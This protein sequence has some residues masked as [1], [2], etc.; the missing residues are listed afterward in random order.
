[1]AI[2]LW[3]RATSS[4]VQKVRWALGELG[5]SYEHIPLAGR[6]GGNKTPEYLAMN[7]NGTVPT[8]RDG[9]LVLWESHAILRYLAAEYGAASLWPASPG[10]RAICDQ[11]TDWAVAEFQKGWIEV[12][13]LL[14]RTPEAQR[15]AERIE[16]TI[17]LTERL[18]G[19]LDGGLASRPWLGGERFTYA[20]I[21]V[22]V[23]MYRWTTMPIARQSHPN[24]ERW[25][26][27]LRERP[28]YR[29][30]VE[31]DYSELVGRL[32]F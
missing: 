18:L 19:I 15:D 30:A 22:G 31:V 28:A 16:R 24:V 32:S 5:L 7:P 8:L 12:F 13:W 9:D 10:E 4:N 25:H 6:Y 23:A 3:G 21:P 1:M 14:V 11:W 26:R 29:E 20:D 17:A 27:A 2:T